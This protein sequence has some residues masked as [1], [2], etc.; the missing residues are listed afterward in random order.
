M[1]FG[2][3]AEMGTRLLVFPLQLKFKT[4]GLYFNRLSRIG[5]ATKFLLEIMIDNGLKVKT[6]GP[7]ETAIFL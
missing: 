5:L 7:K 4:M 6:E 2:N 1:N 3:I